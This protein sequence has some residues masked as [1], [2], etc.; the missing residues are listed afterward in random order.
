MPYKLF[1]ALSQILPFISHI[2]SNLGFHKNTYHT[3]TILGTKLYHLYKKPKLIYLVGKTQKAQQ[4]P[5]KARCYTSPLKA[6]YDTAPQKARYDTAPL[7]SCYDT[8]PLKL[9]ATWH[10]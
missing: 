1:W 10:L 6:C 4:N 7:K 5:L 8:A 2:L 3:I 9:V